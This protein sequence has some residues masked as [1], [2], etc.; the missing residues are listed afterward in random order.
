MHRTAAIAFV[1][2][3]PQVIHENGERREREVVRQDDADAERRP[4]A[5]LTGN[6]L[7]R[8]PCVVH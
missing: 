5:P 7:V 3:Q 8:D 6:N 2:R 4:S 1:R